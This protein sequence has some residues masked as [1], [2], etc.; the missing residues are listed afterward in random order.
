MTIVIIMND[1]FELRVKC[2]DYEIEK[3]GIGSITNIMFNGI[4]ENKPI[5][6]PVNKIKYIYRVVSDE[7]ESD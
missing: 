7:M 1:D 4:K 5:Y 6:L 3:N 2:K